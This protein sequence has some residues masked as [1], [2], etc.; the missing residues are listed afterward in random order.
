MDS[1]TIRAYD[2]YHEV[3]DAETA[4]FWEDFPEGIID[5]FV[6]DLNGTHILD[7]GSGPGRDALK[8]REKGLD[9]VCLDGSE[10]MVEATRKLGFT[11]MLCDF[12]NMDLPE[13]T[14]DGV[15]AYSSLIHVTLEEAADILSALQN[16]LKI[17]GKLFMGL[18]QGE[19][20]EEVSLGGSEYSRYF[21]YYNEAKLDLL[22]RDT[23]LT[24]KWIE[25]YKPGN[26]VYL[27]ILLEN[28]AAGWC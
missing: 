17:G 21:E 10:N 14:F 7:L 24:L 28:S 16:S 4:D 26:Q 2:L 25:T 19:G 15:W 12:R 20:N 11:S 6:W 9:V 3:Y 18:I 5:R 27:N 8:L 22:F 23:G 13:R 1:K